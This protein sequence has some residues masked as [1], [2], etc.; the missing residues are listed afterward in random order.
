MYSIYQFTSWFALQTVNY[1]EIIDFGAISTPLMT[2]FKKCNFCH[3]GY[4]QRHMPRNSQ[5][6]SGQ[7]ATMLLV[8]EKTDKFKYNLQA[9]NTSNHHSLGPLYHLH[10]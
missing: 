8:V 6:L 5:R 2:S 9:G 7:R 10:V 1:D 3:G 4:M